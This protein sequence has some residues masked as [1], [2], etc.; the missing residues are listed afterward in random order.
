MGSVRRRLWIRR[1]VMP[2]PYE[3]YGFEAPAIDIQDTC[4]LSEVST[5]MTQNELDRLRTA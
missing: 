4:E 2:V 3:A 5:G 1:N